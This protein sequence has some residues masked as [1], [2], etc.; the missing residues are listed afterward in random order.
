MTV[1]ETNEIASLSDLEDID[2]DLSADYVV[3][4]DIDADGQA[5]DPIA[6]FNSDDFEGTLDGNGYSI[7]DLEIDTGV[8]SS[9]GLFGST[10]E[11]AVIENLFLE[12]TIEDAENTAGAFVGGVHEGELREVHARGEIIGDGGGNAGGLVSDNG[13]G[14]AP[15]GTIV[16]SRSDVVITGSFDADVGGITA[17]NREG[18]IENSFAT[19]EIDSGADREGGLAAL[20]FGGTI[21]GS[22]WD[23]ESTGQDTS[24]GGGTGLETDEMQGSDAETNMDALDFDTVW[25][26]V[27]DPDDYPE[28]RVLSD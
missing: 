18:T 8:G 2:N 23:T 20:D 5:I 26:T 11:D 28:L 25:Q 27:T 9:H 22:Y 12:V 16:N 19:G 21:T 1:E 14:S 24:D 7:T 10:G 6:V 17:I 15:Y 4:N 13:G 3:V